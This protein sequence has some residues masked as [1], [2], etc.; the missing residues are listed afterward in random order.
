VTKRVVKTVQREEDIEKIRDNPLRANRL[1]N[2]F[3][4]KNK[5]KTVTNFNVN[6]VG[7]GQV[8]G[9]EDVV[10]SGVY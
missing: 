7:P 4:S 8:I 3:F 2:A 6:I 5:I 10:T 1:Q 9:E